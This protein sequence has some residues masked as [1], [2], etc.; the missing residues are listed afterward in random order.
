MFPRV[1]VSPAAGS[2][3]IVRPP[4][5]A[6]FVFIMLRIA[7]RPTPLYSH[8]CELPYMFSLLRPVRALYCA[9]PDA[10]P[11]G[12]YCYKLF[13]IAGKVNSFVFKQIRTLSQKHPGWGVHRSV[14][15]RLCTL[16]PSGSDRSTGGKLPRPGARCHNSTL[17]TTRLAHALA[18]HHFW[19]R[20]PPAPLLLGVTHDG[21]S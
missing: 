21:T 20:S 13:G 14:F 8:S 5:R 10:N 1:S 6:P 19:H 4:L 2:K 11:C 12:S 15:P 7:F 17:R 9:F 16:Q 3:L 18:T